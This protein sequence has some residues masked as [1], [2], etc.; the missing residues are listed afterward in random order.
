VLCV[1]LSYIPF[2]AG[3][4]A[5][6]GQREKLFHP[7]QFAQGVV[8]EAVPPQ[9]GDGDEHSKDASPQP[10]YISKL[11]GYFERAKAAL[12]EE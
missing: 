11:I 6:A 10:Y 3:R 5:V 12:E 4:G 8:R 9:A 7:F 1:L 2:D